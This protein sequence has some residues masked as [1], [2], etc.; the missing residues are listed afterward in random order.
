LFALFWWNLGFST[1][2]GA[3][4]WTGGY[5]FYTR[6]I[7][8]TSVLNQNNELD[9]LQSEQRVWANLRFQ[10]DSLDGD[11]VFRERQ[12]NSMTASVFGD[13]LISRLMWTYS[14]KQD[15]F[16][17]I[18]KE[19]L[20]FGNSQSE[21]I[22]YLGV[23]KEF[24]SGAWGLSVSH[25]G[26]IFTTSFFFL[27]VIQSSNDQ[28][29]N[30]NKEMVSGLLIS[31]L[32]NGVESKLL[33]NYQVSDPR[34]AALAASYA[35]P[36]SSLV[37][38]LDSKL[39]NQDNHLKIG[40]ERS[41][42]GNSL[43][44]S[45]PTEVR[46]FSPTVAGLSFSLFDKSTVWIDVLYDGYSLNK[47]ES[48]SILSELENNAVARRQFLSVLRQNLL[49]SWYC[50]ITEIQQDIFENATLQ[51]YWKV[52]LADFSSIFRGSIR[53]FL[54]SEMTLEL[55]TS[56]KLSN[57]PKTEFGSYFYNNETYFK[58]TLSF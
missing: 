39:V 19:I 27:P 9:L 58:T 40:I 15:I 31:S 57:N 38:Y 21:N 23:Q 46:L 12:L 17:S 34:F 1:L 2:Y 4:A 42:F 26:N 18:G 45:T 43:T 55:G 35:V 8:I 48:K 29:R 22:L 54:N 37:I 25:F 11:I 36:D 32:I 10:S 56:I 33:F 52:N 16:L 44:I 41:Q 13:V 24:I 51:S 20:K 47:E 28:L 6:S 50:S 5:E 7:N 3:T 49:S 14:P 30:E 53:Y